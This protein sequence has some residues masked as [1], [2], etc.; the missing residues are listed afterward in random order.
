MS[1]TPNIPI[2]EAELRQIQA[3]LYRVQARWEPWKALAAI[4]ATS[5]VLAGTI[6]GLANYIGRSPQT[7]V[8]HF[9]QPVSL[10]GKP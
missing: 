2:S 4:V 8:V 9:D 3:D 1:G 7:I 5:A 6:L 10:Q